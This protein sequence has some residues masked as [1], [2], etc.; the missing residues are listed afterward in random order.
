VLG[1]PL[2]ATTADGIAIESVYCLGNCA[3][4][5]A[6]LVD[7]RLVGRV[8]PAALDRVLDSLRVEEGL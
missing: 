3:L 7:G 6:A 2:G 8:D 1:G 4:G 5:P